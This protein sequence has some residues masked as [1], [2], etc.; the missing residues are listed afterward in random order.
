MALIWVTEFFLTVIRT[1]MQCLG[2]WW[3][4]HSVFH[5]TNTP[6]SM[7]TP[8]A[9]NAWQLV[10]KLCVSKFPSTNNFTINMSTNIIYKIRT[11]Q[12]TLIP[13]FWQCFWTCQH[14][15]AADTYR[16]KAT[17]IPV[18]F[19][20]FMSTGAWPPVTECDQNMTY[21]AQLEDYLLV[22]EVGNLE[23]YKAAPRPSI[24]SVYFSLCL[25]RL[26]TTIHHWRSV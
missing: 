15:N 9:L 11:N 14:L 22:T 23:I 25:T 26:K 10:C 5:L 17:C 1:V 4:C 12:I 24:T 7:E 19:F 6:P 3:I 13:S 8:F 2:I 20:L 16:H 21:S 18:K